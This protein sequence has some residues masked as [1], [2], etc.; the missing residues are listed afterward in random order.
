MR[1]FSWIGNMQMIFHPRPQSDLVSIQS[2]L[3][4]Y[5]IWAA[6][7]IGFTSGATL[8]ETAIHQDLWIQAVGYLRGNQTSYLSYFLHQVFLHTLPVFIENN[9]FE[10]KRAHFYKIW[11][12]LCQITCLF[13]IYRCI[14]LCCI[15][16]NTMNLHGWTWYT[17]NRK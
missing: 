12:I 8:F 13:E 15:T 17:G 11:Q 14:S 1:R 16:S 7:H 5:A 3:I 2:S 10:V 4:G 6:I 9:N